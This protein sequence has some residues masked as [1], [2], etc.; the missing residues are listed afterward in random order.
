MNQSHAGRGA[1]DVLLSAPVP[2]SPPAPILSDAPPR[3]VGGRPRALNEAKRVAL[4]RLLRQGYTRRDAAE[5]VGVALS[6]I[7]LET[8]RDVHFALELRH[9]EVEGQEFRGV[10]EKLFIPGRVCLEEVPVISTPKFEKEKEFLISKG[11]SREWVSRM[12]L[13]TADELMDAVRKNEIMCQSRERKGLNRT[14]EQ[15]RNGLCGKEI[16]EVRYSPSGRYSKVMKTT[17]LLPPTQSVLAERVHSLETL[18]QSSGPEL[19]AILESHDK[20]TGWNKTKRRKKPKHPKKQKPPGGTGGEE[21]G[22]TSSTVQSEGTLDAAGGGSVLPASSIRR[23]RERRAGLAE[24]HS[25]VNVSK[26]SGDS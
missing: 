19:K 22:T 21:R 26:T 13:R 2:A 16:I 3:N 15:A 5:Q 10:F 4:F 24:V 1:P 11:V 17:R 25:F 9:V 8:R 6:T 7:R 20:A 23:R 14:L 18:L 12:R